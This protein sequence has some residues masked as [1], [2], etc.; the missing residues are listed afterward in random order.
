MHVDDQLL[1]DWLHGICLGTDY[2]PNKKL[3]LCIYGQAFNGKMY[4][5]HERWELP[6]WM[7]Y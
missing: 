3:V 7:Y 6:N 1:L 5:T 2:D 4:V